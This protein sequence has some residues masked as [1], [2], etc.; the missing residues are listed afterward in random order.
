MVTFRFNLRKA[1]AV[2]ICFAASAT[3]FA[4]DRM[5][6]R[7]PAHKRAA[8]WT[9]K[10]NEF[11]GKHAGKRANLPKKR[12]PI[13]RSTNAVMQR[14]DSIVW[15]EDS[16]MSFLYN[17]QGNLT[18]EISSD[19]NGTD[20]EIYR[21]YE[22]TYDGNGNQ[23]L[24]I[25][26]DWNGAEWEN[27]WK[28][29]YTYDDN[30]NLTQVISYDWNGTE[31]KNWD[32]FEYTYDDNGNQMQE[33]YSDWNGTEWKN[34]DKYE[35]TYDDNGNQTQVIYSHWNGAEWENGWKDEYTYTYDDNRNLTQVIEN[36]TSK[37]EYTYDSNGNQTQEIG[38]YWN[39][40]DWKIRYKCEYVYDLTYSSSSLIFPPSMD[41]NDLDFN[42][43]NKNNKITE[44][45][46]Y[47]WDGTDW[48]FGGTQTFY[49]SGQE[50]TG[51]SNILH[52][53]IQVYPNPTAGE[54][55]INIAPLAVNRIV[56]Y[57]VTG[58][59]MLTA[60][61]SSLSTAATLDIS[62]LPA[63]AYFLRIGTETVKVIKN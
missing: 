10:N 54:L 45:K 22:Y 13:L 1:V 37:Y 4:Q 61:V 44:I 53:A 43:M 35:Y 39:G 62:N 27:G 60:S 2:A 46:Y 21:K 33:I 18:Q 58:R 56:L 55:T 57:D 32:K 19:W 26:Y 25:S 29:E 17:T 24:E 48:K 40:T 59:V 47:G 16:K 6:Q 20:W 12:T 5:A 23:T 9:Q 28:D 7:L 8:V 51:M 52:N 14:L 15:Q 50:A 11:D 41:D 31:W 30:G 49:W 36:G 42:R 38:S 3:L 63:G 34:R